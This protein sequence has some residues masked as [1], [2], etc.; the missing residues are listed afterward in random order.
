MEILAEFIEDIMA[1]DLSNDDKIREL[2]RILVEDD[3]VKN[4]KV[5]IFSE[6]ILF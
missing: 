1:I 3:R 6:Y 4:K 2:K 5:I